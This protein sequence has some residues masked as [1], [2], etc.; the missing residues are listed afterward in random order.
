MKMDLF[1]LS[2]LVTVFQASWSFFVSKS[3]LQW[4]RNRD[5][6]E[7]ATPTI[8]YGQKDLTVDMNGQAIEQEVWVGYY[9]QTALFEYIG[10]M[11]S[12]DLD[13][14]IP[15]IQLGERNIG[16]CYS[17]CSHSPFIGIQKSK[18]YCIPD[19][20]KKNIRQLGCNYWCTDRYNA[21]CGGHTFISVYRMLSH[22]DSRHI[23]EKQEY[24]KRC[25]R[26][27]ID[28]TGNKT[29][30]WRLCSD[31]MWVFCTSDFNQSVKICYKKKSWRNAA[32]LCFQTHGYPIGYENVRNVIFV[33]KYG[34]AG[35]VWSDVIF[36]D[37]D[38]ENSKTLLDISYGYLK[39]VS[40]YGYVLH[41]SKEDTGKYILCNDTSVRTETT[42]LTTIARD[43]SSTKHTPV[44][45]ETTQLTT[46]TSDDNSSPT[47]HTHITTTT[48]ERLSS[49]S[50]SN[51]PN[52]HVCFVG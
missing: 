25:L 50:W 48:T 12:D 16:R 35:I 7:I 37:N 27:D 41:F 6:C 44:E 38:L 26:L 14:Q 10:C 43:T 1:F 22:N 3:T 46:I 52:T 4:S 13:I 49:T 32:S 42:K 40:P 33:A 24:K 2:V 23:P 15:K 28:Q 11:S 20:P 19:I 34:W 21:A 51:T 45:K 5:G 47:K 8:Q 29:Y 17:A 36:N 30:Q 31:E 39:Y 9:Q 18:C